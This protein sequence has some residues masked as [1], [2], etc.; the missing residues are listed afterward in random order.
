VRVPALEVHRA[1]DDERVIEAPATTPRAAALRIAIERVRETIARGVAASDGG[2]VQLRAHDLRLALADVAA[3][4]HAGYLSF[5]VMPRRRADGGVDLVLSEVHAGFWLSTCLLDILPPDDRERVLGQMR[6][7]VRDMARGRRT[8]ECVFLQ[9]GAADRRFPI[10]TL[11]LEML[12]PSERPDALDLAALEIRLVGDELEFLR[13]DEEIVPIVAF[14]RYQFLYYTSKLV[15]MFDH[16]SDRFFPDGLLPDGLRD[17]DL[18]RLSVDDIVVQRRLWRRSVAAVRAALA[19]QTEAEL[20]HRAQALRRELGCDPRVF[21]SVSGEPKP[22]LIDFHNVFL[23]EALVNLLDRRPD[24][25]IV[26]FSEMLPGPDEL[27]CRAPDGL[28]TA[29]LRMG[30]YR[31]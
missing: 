30:C 6:A 5:D 29:E 31:T 18:P 25:A 4:A 19:A 10:A 22:V 12:A 7:A 14:N 27:V 23:L 26:K 15:P 13:G 8:A 11:D 2:R 20:F 28:R 9:I 3:P 24:D 16:N 1:F 17:R 21:V